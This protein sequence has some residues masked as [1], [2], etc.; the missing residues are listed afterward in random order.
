MKKSTL[1]I[2]GTAMIATAALLTQRVSARTPDSVFFNRFDSSKNISMSGV[3][4]GVP[5]D[6][7]L[8][9][10][11]TAKSKGQFKEPPQTTGSQASIPELKVI[12][13]NGSFSFI[14]ATDDSGSTITR[15]SLDV[16]MTD[17]NPLVQKQKDPA[18]WIE[19]KPEHFRAYRLSNNSYLLVFQSPL[20]EPV[21]IAYN[22]IEG[23]VDSRKAG[24]AISS[25]DVS[26][27]ST[28]PVK[29][30]EVKLN[31]G[32]ESFYVTTGRGE[33]IFVNKP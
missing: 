17:V 28:S 19:I 2:A 7:I 32:N 25:V 5:R 15:G 11:N 13:E 26:I 27:A 23:T 29:V 21:L 10:L 1:F 9:S 31:G 18:S 12:K 6:A 33:K 14:N 8:V 24:G 20:L 4:I 16:P 22:A 30:I 3:P